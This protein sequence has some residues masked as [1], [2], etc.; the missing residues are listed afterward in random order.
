MMPFEGESFTASFDE[1]SVF[2]LKI[3]CYL[4][5]GILLF[6]DAGKPMSQDGLR[7]LTD[8]ERGSDLFYLQDKSG[9]ILVTHYTFLNKKK[10]TNIKSLLLNLKKYHKHLRIYFQE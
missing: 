10:T 5:G 1:K 9:K 4:E 6:D 7:L 2:Y 8:Y 3:N